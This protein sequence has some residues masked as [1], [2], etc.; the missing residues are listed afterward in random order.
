MSKL[1]LPLVPSSEI[2]RGVMFLTFI[3]WGTSLDIFNAFS[4]NGIIE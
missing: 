4:R 1:P 2:Y 3:A